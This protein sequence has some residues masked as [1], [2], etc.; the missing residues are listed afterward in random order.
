[1][2]TVNHLHRVPTNF[3]VHRNLVGPR[4]GQWGE[5]YPLVGVREMRGKHVNMGRTLTFLGQKLR[6]NT[7]NHLH[8][9]TT[10]FFPTETS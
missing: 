5:V 4:G 7:V 10:E 3:S 9:V 2:N 6:M 8:R 1:M